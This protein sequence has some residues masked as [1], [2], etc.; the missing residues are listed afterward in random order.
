MNVLGLQ[1]ISVPNAEKLPKDWIH[2]TRQY[3]GKNELKNIQIG[4]LGMPYRPTAEPPVKSLETVVPDSMGYELHA[5]MGRL[6]KEVGSINEYVRRYMGYRNDSEL[7]AALSAEQVD[8]VALAIYNIEVRQEG[9]ITGDQ[10]GIGKGRIAASLIRIYARMGLKPVFITE[11]PNLF[12]DIYRDLV[13]IGS[14]DLVPFIVNGRAGKTNVLNEDGK[15]VY[16]ASGKA[17]QDAAFQSGVVPDDCDYVMATYSQFADKA[18]M[19]SK[20]AKFTP[21]QGFL[22]AVSKRNVLIL[23][24]SHNAGG[25]LTDS[26]TGK[27]FYDILKWAKGVMFLSATFAKRAD[28]MP[29]YASSTCISEAS[30]PSEALIEAIQKGGVALQEVISASLVNEGQLVR[31]ERSFDGVEVNYITL[32][33]DGAKYYDVEDLEKKH[34][35]TLDSI[36]TVLRQIIKF[37]EV[38]ITPIIQALD[39]LLAEQAEQME[40]RKGTKQMGANNSPMFSKLF[41][42]NSQLLFSIKAESVADRAI[43]RL[44]EGKK[45]VIAF[46]STMGSFLEKML[47]GNMDGEA[48][49]ADDETLPAE[50]D[51]DGTMVPDIAGLGAADDVVIN[52]DFSEV[53]FRAL[54]GT[55]SVSIIASDGTT[56]KKRLSLGELSPEGEAEYMR[57]RSGIKKMT[58]GIGLSPIDV[59]K[60]KL[61][62]AGYKTSE[63]TGRRLALESLGNGSAA[64]IVTRPKENVV[65]AFR[66]FNNNE[67]DVL[68]INQSGSTGASAHAIVTKRVPMEKVKQRVMIV[69]QPELDIN[70]EVQKRGRINRTGQIYQPIYDY[71]S[72]AIPAELRLNMMLQRKL[73]SL[74]ANTTSNQKQSK[75]MMDYPDF[76]NKYGDRVVKA[77]LE[78]NPEM[79]EALGDLLD[80][81]ETLTALKASGRVAVLSC[82]AQKAFYDAVF[83]NYQ[84]AVAYAKQSGEYDLEVEEMNLDAETKDRERFIVGSGGRSDFGSD[85]YLEK[86]EANVLTKPFTKKEVEALI[87][88]NLD[89]MDALTLQKKQL[90]D[91]RGFFAAKKDNEL[92][93]ADVALQERIKNIPK[94]KLYEEA[95]DKKQVTEE[96]TAE[97]NED[98][99][100]KR[101]SIVE[102]LDETLRS[103]TNFFWNGK[104]G[105]SIVMDGVRGVFLG[106]KINQLK[107]NPYA[108]SAITAGFAL[109]NSTR[110]IELT[111]SGEQG[112]LAK[113]VLGEREDSDVLAGWDE[114]TKESSANRRIRYIYTGNLLQAFAKV[115]GDV[116]VAAPDEK[117]SNRGKLIS[118]TCK[119]GEVRKGILMPE[120]WEPR[121]AGNGAVT[122]LVPLKFCRK[123]V[124][125]LSRG[126]VLTTDADIDFMMGDGNIR[127]ITR[128]LNQQKFGWLIKNTGIL[129]VIRENGGFQKTGSTWVGSVELRDIDRAIDV[130]Y[131]ESRCNANLSAAQMDIV[132]PDIVRTEVKPTEKAHI[133]DLPTPDSDKAKRLKLLKMKAI[134]K[135]KKLRLLA[136]DG[137]DGFDNIV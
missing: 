36:T 35:Q 20:G 41:M 67:V 7:A 86:V 110:Y 81:P 51:I 5:A 98:W 99:K 33:R 107:Q 62:K 24:E 91:M 123:A 29:I 13:A 11:K 42:L 49:D 63:V 124:I 55:L 16:H 97:Y 6:K 34:W 48:G 125:S 68:L 57:L 23:D 130:I 82:A 39:K 85:S 72:S 1:Y 73:K 84:S 10:T 80:K 127:I 21:K 131:E 46:A 64:K 92:A 137:T 78:D 14:G 103:L 25:N 126:S 106:F 61:E 58:A 56:Q 94:T 89:G 87:Q 71:I 19:T 93:K 12:S 38:H 116:E 122:R 112:T 111:L 113:A 15:V 65:D 90:E 105:R 101:N 8:A 54:E 60:T 44:K 128:S 133:P 77:Y 117:A 135:A 95:A 136:L 32:N 40:K 45:P 115:I 50:L 75:A 134:A 31:R 76:L 69:L 4:G 88:K 27:L 17:E 102:K 66:R 59:I 3:L 37:E 121:R 30:M 53:L 104:V 26:A 120:A 129:P 52:N 118:F 18:Y 9:M 47:Y 22:I 109:C 43:Q 96:L 28:N 114:Y 108:P 79:N 132:E 2:R 74:D 119:N 70:K 83:E 100:R